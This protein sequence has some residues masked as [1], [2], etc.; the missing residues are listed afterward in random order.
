MRSTYGFVRLPDGTFLWTQYH[1]TPGEGQGFGFKR[2]QTGPSLELAFDAGGNRYSCTFTT[3]KTNYVPP[4][5]GPEKAKWPTRAIAA[6]EL[7]KRLRFKP[8]APDVGSGFR[9]GNHEINWVDLNPRTSTN[10]YNGVT[11]TPQSY[12]PG[13]ALCSKVY[14]KKELVGYLIQAPSAPVL[15]THQHMMSIVGQGYFTVDSG[16]G[17][18]R[19]IGVAK[20]IDYVIL[21]RTMTTEDRSCLRE[22][23]GDP[24]H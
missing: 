5:S 23:L 22:A 14:L 12:R 24:E 6:S 2:F 18:T 9:L 21:S 8:L 17:T 10:T 15:G 4:S 13:Q 16:V 1:I 20:G 19:A 11:L 3:F 7:P